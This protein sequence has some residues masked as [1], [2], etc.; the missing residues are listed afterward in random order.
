MFMLLF[1]AWIFAKAIKYIKRIALKVFSYI[2]KM[3]LKMLAE[4]IR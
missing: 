1:K 2:L 4:E 3:Q